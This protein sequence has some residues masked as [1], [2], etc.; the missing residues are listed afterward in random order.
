MEERRPQ[1]RLDEQTKANSPR[2]RRAH[3][4]AKRHK[5]A[6]N[7]FSADFGAPLQTQG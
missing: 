3:S 1:R 6:A 7:H 2:Q 4:T 5:S